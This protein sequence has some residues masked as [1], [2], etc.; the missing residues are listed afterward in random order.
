MKKEK[1]KYLPFNFFICLSSWFAP[2]LLITT[3]TSLNIWFAVGI[4]FYIYLTDVTQSSKYDYLEDRIKKLED[5][6]LIK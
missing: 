1:L 5:N 2:F 4:S 3:F 6:N